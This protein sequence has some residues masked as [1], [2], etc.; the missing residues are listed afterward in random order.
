MPGKKIAIIFHEQDRKRPGSYAVISLAH[1]WKA[2]GIDPFFVFGTKKV[3]PADL[4]LVHVNLS[5]VPDEY[6]EYARDYPYALN[7]KVRDIRK[8]SFSK[9]RVRP[10]DLYEGRVIVKSNLNYAG[11]PERRTSGNPSVWSR[12]VRK[13]AS[14]DPADTRQQ[15]CFTS[16]LDYLIFDHRDLVPAEWFERTDIIVEKFLPEI[17]NGSYCIR[18]YYFL[19]DRGICVMK[20]G[21][22]PIVNSA[23]TTR[24]ERVQVHPDILSLQK[25]HH[26]DYGKFDYTLQEN[27]PVFLDMNKTPGIGHGSCPVDP[28]LHREWAAGIFSYFSG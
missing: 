24:I 9:N 7:G 19:G 14:Q 18:N 23:T 22:H 16:P 6:L 20:M 13:L 1:F 2:E 21:V 10:D 15:P 4:A 5:V 28:L 27:V 25:T 26:F 11:K 17:R 8:S 3:L 12:F